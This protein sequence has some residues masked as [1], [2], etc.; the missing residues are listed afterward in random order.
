MEHKSEKKVK[1]SRI[2]NVGKCINDAF[3]TSVNKKVS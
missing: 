1:C 2:D 3:V